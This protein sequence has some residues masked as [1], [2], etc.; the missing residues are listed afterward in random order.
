MGNYSIFFRPRS[1]SLRFLE[2][3]GQLMK[4]D[5]IYEC[6]PRSHVIVAMCPRIASMFY[7]AFVAQSPPSSQWIFFAL[8]ISR[9][10]RS[11]GRGEVHLRFARCSAW[12]MLRFPPSLPSSVFF[13]PRPSHSSP[14]RRRP[15]P[16]LRGSVTASRR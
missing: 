15:L 5:T 1:R 12:D 2:N 4:Y 7:C 10:R 14:P 6:R 13:C 3:G 9:V 11:R 8:L 16:P